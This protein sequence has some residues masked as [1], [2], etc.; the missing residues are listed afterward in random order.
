MNRTLPAPGISAARALWEIVRFLGRR[1]GAIAVSVGLLLVNIGIELYLP[2]IPGDA[3]TALGQPEPPPGFS[4]SRSVLALMALVTLRAGI[5]LFLGP[6]RNLTAQRTLGDIRSAVYDA[7]QRRAFSWHDNARTGELISRASTDVGRLQE[8]IFVCLLF[9][10]DIAA[11][12]LG[13]LALVFALSPLLGGLTL[14]ALAPTVAAM[15]FFAVRLQPRWRRV[16]DRHGAMSTVIQENIAGVRVVK[17]F[18]RE[19]AQVARFRERR[20]D[21]LR[22]LLDAVNYW[23]ARVPFAQFVFGLGVPLILWAGGRQVIAGELPLGDLAKALFYLITLGSRIGVI[24]QVTNIVQNA[25]SAAQRIHEILE[26]PGTPHEPREARGTANPPA[27]GSIRFESV[28]FRHPRIPSLDL[29][30]EGSAPGP[31]PCPPERAAGA[32]AWALEAVSFEIHPGETVAVVGPTGAGKSSLLALIPRFYDPDAGEVRVDG[33]DVRAFDRQALRRRTAIVFQETFLFSASVADN[34]A[35]G[36]PD[37]GRDAIVQAA[38]AARADGFIRELAQGYE[39][40]VGERG[41]SL[42]GGQRQR[43]ALARALLMDPQ[44]L[45]LDDVTSAVDPTTE[46]EMRE[47]LTALMRG[48]TTLV[49]SQRLATVRRADRVLVLDGGRLVDEGP[50]AA[51]LTRAGPFLD[52]FRSQLPAKAPAMAPAAVPA[53][54]PSL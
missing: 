44:I 35:F 2:Q 28:S 29:R 51:L 47:T 20:D 24:G 39:T 15:G 33:V 30:S 38:V 21:Y 37:A 11:G 54:T 26:P 17:A 36:R 16:H 3:I 10:V 50:P 46:R 9:S 40:V 6:L 23:A 7:L 19:A 18:A 53:I 14:L 4:L 12:V 5:G 48:R 52:L 41:V 42:S 13:T 22:E 43:L 34:I 31:A 49:V 1:P 25:S 32:R 45:L 27:T 8:F